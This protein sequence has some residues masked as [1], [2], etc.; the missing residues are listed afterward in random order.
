MEHTIHTIHIGD[1]VRVESLDPN[2]QYEFGVVKKI[3]GETLTL[4]M[5]LNV[6][7]EGNMSI[8]YYNRDIRNALVEPLT[9][10]MITNGVIT[11]R[12]YNE[13]IQFKNIMENKKDSSGKSVL[14]R[15]KGRRKKTNKKRKSKSSRSKKRRHRK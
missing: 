4:A 9:N 15:A 14:S 7:H 8:T 10:T 6:V 1:L 11:Q 3:K 5:P 2:Q 12:Q 13:A